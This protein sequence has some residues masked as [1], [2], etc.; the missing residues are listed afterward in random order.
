MHVYEFEGGAELLKKHR[1]EV[2]ICTAV[3]L[4]IDNLSPESMTLP[5]KS[6]I[7]NRT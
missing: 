7:S 5:F 4:N 3:D 1:K 2:C 6:H